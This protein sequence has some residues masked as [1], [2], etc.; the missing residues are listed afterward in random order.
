MRHLDDADLVNTAW[1]DPLA[2]LDGELTALRARL[3]A[4]EAAVGRPGPLGTPAPPTLPA[5]AQRLATL[6]RQAGI[7]PGLD[8]L[9]GTQAAPTARSASA[10]PAPSSRGQ[11]WRDRGQAV[12]AALLLL[13]VFAW[14]LRLPVQSQDAVLPPAASASMAPAPSTPTPLTVPASAV[15]YPVAPVCLSPVGAAGEDCATPDQ[16]ALATPISD[17]GAGWLAELV[18]IPPLLATDRPPASQCGTA[19]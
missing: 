1:D 12:L 5:L 17:T 11:V 8:L 6:E 7:V 10:T 15:P 9:T 13:A 19:C 16:P 3:A 2:R 4:V 18:P 14:L